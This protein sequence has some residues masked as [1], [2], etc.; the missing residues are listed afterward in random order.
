MGLFYNVTDSFPI[1]GTLAITQASDGSVTAATPTP[2]TLQSTYQTETSAHATKTFRT[3]GYSKLNLDINY[4]M[5]SGETGCSIQTKIECSPDGI[6]FF[7]IPNESVSGG[8]STMTD[9]EFTYVGANAALAS[10]SI[11]LDIFYEYVRVSCK[12]TGVVTNKGTVYTQASLL[13]K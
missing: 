9:R 10:T 13:G 8:V 1:H 5:G 3:K 4:T 11:G 7:R 6:N 12:E 2:V